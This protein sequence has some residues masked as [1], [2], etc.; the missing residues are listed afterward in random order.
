MTVANR[1]QLGFPEYRSARIRS[2]GEVTEPEGCSFDPF[3]EIVE[4]FGGSIRY[5]GGSSEMRGESVVCCREPRPV[6]GACGGS[7]WSKGERRSPLEQ[8]I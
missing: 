7:V 4:G 8:T 3:D 6:C 5:L 2:F 1:S